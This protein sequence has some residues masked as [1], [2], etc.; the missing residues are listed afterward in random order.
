MYY[1]DYNSYFG[2]GY[3]IIYLDLCNILLQKM[4]GIIHCNE[5]DR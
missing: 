2:I 5:I 1:F 4:T 3:S